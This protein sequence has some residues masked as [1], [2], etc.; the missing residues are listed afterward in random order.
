MAVVLP[1]AVPEERRIRRNRPAFLN[2]TGGMI[3]RRNLSEKK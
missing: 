2:G 1:K 3:G